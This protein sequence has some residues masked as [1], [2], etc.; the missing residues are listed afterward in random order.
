MASK[1]RFVFRDR[2]TGHGRQGW[3]WGDEDLD[4]IPIGGRM[5][6]IQRASM[7]HEGEMPP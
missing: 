3:G 1:Q 2:Q 4:L 7:V 6:M 5:K